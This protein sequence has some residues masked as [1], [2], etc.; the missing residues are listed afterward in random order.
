M[1]ICYMSS[2]IASFVR[3]IQ[4]EKRFSPHTVLSYTNDLEQFTAYLGITSTPVTDVKHFHIRSWMVQL[5]KDNNT[6]RTINRKI[7]ALKSFYKFLLRSNTISESPLAKVTTP[8]VSKRLP[9]FVEQKNIDQLLSDITFEEGYEGIRDK[10]IIELFYATGMR[11]SELVSIQTAD[12]DVYNSQIKV[13]GKGNKQRILPIAPALMTGLKKYLSERQDAFEENLSNSL[14]LNKK[15]GALKDYEAYAIVKK[16]LS[17]VTTL[18]KKSPHV[19]RHTFA[20]H[21]LNEGADINAVKELL[22]HSSLAATQV[23]T[24]NTIERLKSVHKQAHPR[25]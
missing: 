5:M 7:S 22:G 2:E 13:L 23:Y 4:Y 10:T 18:E 19:L 16:Y 21:M 17:M 20:T 8:K 11:R 12:V 14:F 25:G 1:Y 9:V 3:F 15:G 6:P 24:H